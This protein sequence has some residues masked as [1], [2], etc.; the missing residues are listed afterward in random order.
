MFSYCSLFALLH[1]I[2]SCTGTFHIVHC[3]YRSLFTLLHHVQGHFIL[4]TVNGSE[5]VV[6]MSL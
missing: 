1:H 5:V 4:Y 3:D 6:V 2:T